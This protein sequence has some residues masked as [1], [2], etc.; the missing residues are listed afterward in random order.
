[1]ESRSMNRTL[2]FCAGAL[3]FNLAG[4]SQGDVAPP[5]A[6]CVDFSNLPT[7][8]PV[9]LQQDL[10]PIF[11]LSCIA[12]SCHDTSAKE[13]GL[14]LGDP[15]ACGPPGSNCFDPTAKWKYKFPGPID[16]A[17]LSQVATSLVASSMTVPGL[18]RITPGKPDQSFLID[19]IT[20]QENS[21][22]Y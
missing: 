20:G 10:L 6:G 2:L 7:S 1:M 17:L 12:S 16:P 18:Q 8:P 5:A 13:A 4:C 21:K 15:R 11:G 3:A 19:K 9:S 22:Q 14:V